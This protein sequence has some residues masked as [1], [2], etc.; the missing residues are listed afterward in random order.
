MPNKTV[1]VNADS[2]D[3]CRV[4]VLVDGELEGFYIERTDSSTL[5]G[6][7][8]KGKVLN[9]EPAIQAA[10]VDFG[11]N[12]NGFLHVSDIVYALRPK[13][14]NVGQPADRQ[15]V[16]GDSGG[17]HSA[18]GRGKRGA[19]QHILKKHQEI[20]VQVTKD[21]IGDKGPAV[22]TNISIPGRYLVLMPYLERTGVSR[23]IEDEE[24][25]RKLRD[26]L[27][28]LK[29]P[30]GMGII[31]RTA[32]AGHSQRDMRRDL[33]YLA[34]LWK[35]VKDR[36]NREKAPVA[37]YLESDLL[38]RTIRDVFTDD[39]NEIIV[40]TADMV[41]KAQDF[42][43]NVMPHGAGRVK[44]YQETAP[45][46]HHY[47]IEPMLKEITSRKVPI[48]QGGSL[49]FDETE[50]LVAI[51]VNSGKFTEVAN[52]EETAFRTNIAA[53]GIAARHLRLRD[54]GGQIVIDFIDMRDEKKNRELER[55][56]RNALK[57]DKARIRL[58]RL[59]KFGMLEMTRQRMRPGVRKV[60]Y[61]SCQVCDGMGYIKNVE[62]AALDIV[63]AVQNALASGDKRGKK[64]LKVSAPPEVSYA[65]LNHQRRPLSALEDKFAVG[66]EIVSDHAMK[67]ANFTLD[68]S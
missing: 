66:I 62:S 29:P 64:L 28:G 5:V 20:M 9:V 68:F 26:M 2:G 10:F 31:A 13:D 17:G 57:G 25:R 49:V 37:L 56:F 58:G 59:S 16:P 4:A 8:Y 14:Q 19:I 51:D 3:E 36:F 22:T 65:L 18:H 47:K 63:R 60:T 1:L 50:A 41:K 46:F 30:E 27:S 38:I 67:R 61:S 11:H 53:A 35:T 15:N 40:D 32:G 7:V 44:L 24:E 48:P 34:R 54:L 42:F 6:N 55:A 23:K 39:T 45:I 43:R 33:S 52:P 12:R 21:A